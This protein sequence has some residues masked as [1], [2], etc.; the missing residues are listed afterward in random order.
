MVQLS[1]SRRVQDA[2]LGR[3]EVPESRR[4]PFAGRLEVRRLVC[5]DRFDPSNE[6]YVRKHLLVGERP[7]RPQRIHGHDIEGDD[8][9]T[10]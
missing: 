9:A 2:R 1:K 6:R 4:G 8:A 5:V 3:N 10:G 7:R